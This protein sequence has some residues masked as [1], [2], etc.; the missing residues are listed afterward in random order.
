MATVLR[1]GTPGKIQFSYIDGERALTEGEIRVEGLISAISHGTELNHVRGTSPFVGRK[2]DE[3]LRVF[4]PSEEGE[5]NA[6]ETLGYEMVALVVEVGPGVTGIVPGNV[7]HTGTPHQDRTI[8]DVTRHDEFGY[9]VTIL[10]SN[11]SLDPALF[12]SLGS[13]ALQAVH[14]AGIKVGDRVLVSGLGTIGLLVTQLAALS[15]AAEIIVS[16]PV[17]SRRALAGKFG[18]TLPLDPGA[19]LDS[20]GIAASIKRRYGAVGADVAI[21]TSGVYAALHAAIASV[22]MAGR[23]VS[24]GFYQGD[25]RGLR[26][27]EEWH[28]N[29]PEL[30]SSM[31]VWGCPHRDYP[32]WGRRRLVEQ[33]RDL[34]YDGRIDIADLLTQKVGFGEAQL[35]YDLIESSAGEVLKVALVYD[36]YRQYAQNGARPLP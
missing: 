17:A 28:H 1:V 2:F 25:G 18:A 35:A 30:V 5:P 36:R 6:S 16:D 11:R 24:V 15:G 22:G 10:P 9:P 33:V 7:V 19:E 34:L 29:R 14:D 23:I 4:V 13:V 32:L 27:G 3:H 12:I 21:E 8:V 31:G 20:G 26:L